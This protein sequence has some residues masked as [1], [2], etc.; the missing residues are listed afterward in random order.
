[1]GKREGAEGMKLGQQVT[2]LE[3][4]EKLK[5]LGYP[6]EGLFWWID[7]SGYFEQQY[8]VMHL[9]ESAFGNKHIT[10]NIVCVAP[11]VA[12]LG[13]WLPFKIEMGK[14]TGYLCI[15]KLRSSFSS[16]VWKVAYVSP[17]TFQTL[18]ECAISEE[19]EAN[20]RAKM[21]IWLVENN[22]LEFKE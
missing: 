16:T 7:V 19:T 22:H 12:E 11:T 2:N 5:E 17:D 1:M 8:A 13:E 9:D 20:A 18:R 15:D 21:L 14:D 4:S 3:L 10:E 6:Q